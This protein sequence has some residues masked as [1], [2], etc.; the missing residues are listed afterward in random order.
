MAAEPR[1]IRHA[2]TIANALGVEVVEV[3]QGG[4]HTKLRLRAPGGE[5][6]LHSIAQSLESAPDFD[7]QVS[8][9]SA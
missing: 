6:R 5:E 1:T 4:R 8:Q 2:T 7:T 3:V 9:R